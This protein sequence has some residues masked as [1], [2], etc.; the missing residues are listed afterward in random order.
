MK[1]Y[2]GIDLGTTNSVICSY[3]CESTRVWKSPEQND[4][5][6][7]A[8]YLD[9]RGN[10]YIGKRAYDNAP[11]S[12]N[13]AAI[14]FKRSM[15]TSTPIQFRD[16]GLTMTP[17]ECSAE[18]LRVLVGYLPEELRTDRIQ[19]TVI[20]VPAAF[21]QMQKN[22]TMHAAEI[23]G[24][25]EVALM[26]EPVAA[27]MSVMNERK[28]D[29]VFVIFDLGG[30]TLDIAL[31]ESISG[32]VN[33]LSHGGIA[34]CGG[35]DF[36]RLLVDSV[37]KPW[38][39]EKFDLPLDLTVNQKYT[40]LMRLSAWSVER[41]KI[42]LSSKDESIISLSETE[43]R[44][45]DESDREIYL[46][47]PV[48]RSTLNNLIDDRV[49]DAI[50]AVREV[51]SK[52]GLQQHDVERLVFVGGPTN[53]KP[54]TEKVSRELGIAASSEVNPMTAVARGAAL[55]AEAIEWNSVSRNRKSS[56]G[57]MNLAGSIDLKFAY[58]SR[59]PAKRAKIV[60]QLNEEP[61]ESGSEFQIDSLS[62]GWSS[63]RISLQHGAVV[64]APLSV[65]GENEFKVRVFK[66]NGESIE[67][68]DDIIRITRTAATVDAIPASHSVGVEVLD[69]LGAPSSLEWLVRSGDQ[70]PKTGIRNFKSSEALKA[71]SSSGSINFN[72]WEGESDVPSDNRY[73][74][75]MK[76]TGNDFEYGVIPAG[77]NLVCDF[78]MQDSGNIV[79]T[80][81]VPSIGGTFHSERN[82]YSRQEGQL[83]FSKEAELVVEKGE[84]ELNRLEE[85]EKMLN[86]P[87]LHKARN[88]LNGF[89]A[90]NPNEMDSE[91]VQEAMENVHEAR[92][93]LSQ[94]RKEN[95][96]AIR[97]MELAEVVA[98]FDLK[99]RQYARPNEERTFDN[100]VQTA[101]RSSERNDTDFESHLNELKNILSEILWRQ[102]WFVIEQFQWLKSSK[103]RFADSAQFDELITS[104][105][106]ALTNENIDQLRNVIGLLMNIATDIGDDL[107]L[108]QI[109][110]IVRG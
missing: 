88:C 83:D 91:Q 79:L 34:M 3:D 53:Y 72:V 96:I 97:V 49:N 87:K 95:L 105:N 7:S 41:A 24:I 38:L 16:I 48:D 29:G 59:T 28:A 11:Y 43:V 90:F 40:S 47:I 45:R 85:M 68:D 66:A 94:V 106:L 58:T 56:R 75:L 101:Q 69:R 108:H 32:A 44:I 81:T 15:G 14:L 62:T 73:I 70:L 103:H 64:D 31:A 80:I 89:T 63:G 10:K 86:D 13:N 36:D 19:G 30:G 84:I 50:N 82:F 5:T 77:A 109:A 26:Q 54:L 39:L 104:G 1:N 98:L 110:N 21:N 57:V 65:Q 23:A 35:R 67:F 27:V 20:T 78:E 76:I 4:V 102:D 33:L 93:I 92:R 99:I 107:D 8:I 22:A 55:F 51:L 61:E 52:A 71:G 18:V 17:E 46:D 100:L 60:A 74:G 25:G 9:R 37:V 12:P 6:P 42:E 2:I